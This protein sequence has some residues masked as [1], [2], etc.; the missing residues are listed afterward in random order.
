MISTVFLA[1]LSLAPME[2]GFVP[3][4]PDGA[5]LFPHETCYAVELNGQV[6]GATRQSVHAAILG[7]RPVWRIEIHQRLPA[8]EFDVRDVFLVD[9]SDLSA[10][11]YESTR[12]ASSRSP[13]RTVRV[14]YGSTA[15]RGSMRVGEAH[16]ELEGSVQYPVWDGNLWGLAFAGMDLHEDARHTLPFWHYEKGE[17]VFNVRVLGS[18]FVP[19]PRGAVDAWVVEAD[20]GSGSTTT[21]WIAKSDHAELGYST[22]PIEQRL[23]GD[24]STFP[25]AFTEAS[26]TERWL[27]DRT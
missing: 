10:I 23:G 22:G 13:A 14:D 16:T 17:G 1:A 7:S 20:G 11:R 26:W 18:E 15:I 25:P 3:D 21:Y 2:P 8:L 6:A 5:R 19:T 24:C 27:G 9:R 4:I 12:L